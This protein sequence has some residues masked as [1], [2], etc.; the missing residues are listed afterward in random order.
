MENVFLVP[1]LGYQLLSVSTLSRRGVSTT[2]VNGR[3]WL[4]KGQ[5]TVASGTLQGTLYNLDVAKG[6]QTKS[7][8]LVSA[9]MDVW[10]KRFAH[11][12]PPSIINMVN[13]NITTGVDIKNSAS[14]GFTCDG[15]VLGKGHRSPIPKKSS[16]RASQILELV[17]SDLNGP[18]DGASL[19][20][21]R[22]FITFI[23]DFSKWTTV[24]MMRKKSESFK[25]F[26]IFHKYAQVHT[27]HQL[28]R[29]NVIQRTNQ[30]MEQIKSLRT[31]NGGEYISNTFKQYLLENGISHQLTVAYTPQ[32]NGVAERMN[33][34]LIDLVR[35]MIHSAGIEKKFW[36]EALQTAVHVRNRVTSRSLPPGK[37]PYHL[38]MKKTPDLAHLRI[39]G[40]DCF[41]TVPK[42][43]TKK[44]DPRCR[45]AIFMGYS[46]QSKGYKLWDP[47]S[48]KMI[49]SRDVTF[50]EGVTPEPEV[51]EIP[52]ESGESINRRGERTV[53]FD[54]SPDENKSSQELTSQEEIEVIED[55]QT[56]PNQSDTCQNE[57]EKASTADED[58][59]PDE[60]PSPRALRRSFRKFTKTKPF[61][62]LYPSLSA[63]ALSARVVPISYK[64]ATTD[65]NIDFF[66]NLESI[67]SMIVYYATIRGL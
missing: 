24:Y 3:C 60:A 43:K 34:T 61:W 48:Q 14:G 53:R 31:D 36:A 67:A 59:D 51:A 62:N 27:G 21:S 23:D 33:R 19:G 66:G 56:P 22:Y 10:H 7:H 16:S 6:G 55:S 5:H 9:T 32:Q 1:E 40:S 15:C 63:H 45:R 35:S 8:A 18:L 44:L 64:K 47:E 52:S 17:H 49:V 28:S 46:T 54:D 12:D 39:F 57:S 58:E 29:L 50:R 65:D 37:T 38:W 42:H 26:Q 25:Y 13:Q 20:G 4:K 41:Y 2:F 30:T 11:V